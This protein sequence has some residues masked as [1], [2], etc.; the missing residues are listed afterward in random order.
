MG[1]DDEQAPPVPA[2][3]DPPAGDPAALY[4]AFAGDLFLA[5]AAEG[6]LVLEAEQAD[7]V[8]AALEETLTVMATRARVLDCW[9]RRIGP[10]A[11]VLD[12]DSDNTVID[13]VFA[14]QMAPGRLERA[15]VELP[16]YLEAFKAARKRATPPSR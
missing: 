3:L 12:R 8:I 15:M 5:L 13:T 4:A 10:V 6:R 14:D 7:R 2:G 16:K 11:D 9:R 1:S